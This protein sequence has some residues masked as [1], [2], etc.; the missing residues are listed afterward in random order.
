MSNEFIK[1]TSF[2]RYGPSLCVGIGIPIPVLDEEMME[3]I[4]VRNKDIQTYVYD[5]GIQRRDKPIIRMVNYEELRSGEILINGKSVKTMPISSLSKAM[6]IMKIL[7]GWIGSGN[8]CLQEPIQM[9]P[10][11]SVCKALGN[12]DYV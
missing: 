12:S 8:F 6:N 1:A 7:K 9:L 5:Y 2:K 3:Y 4:A 11:D 10:D